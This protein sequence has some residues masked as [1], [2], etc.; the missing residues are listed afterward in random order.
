MFGESR[1]VVFLS[2]KSGGKQTAPHSQPKTLERARGRLPGCSEIE[3][4]ISSKSGNGPP[5]EGIEQ[6]KEASDIFERLGNTVDQAECLICL[7]WALLDDKQLDAAEEAVSRAIDLLS[8]KGQQFRVC[9]GHRLLG[10]IYRSKG[11]TK[12]AIHHFEVALG[13]ASS[14][15]N[16]TELFWIHYALA[17]V[18]FGED[19]FD[20]AHAHIERAKSHAINNAYPGSC[21]GA[22]SCVLVPATHV[23]KGKARGFACRRRL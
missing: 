20:D 15:N 6:A 18:F 12:E 22:T 8:E 16:H 5:E 10:L 13:I 23:W 1:T 19:R 9:E 3:G 21:D 17:Q 7:A 14:L 2:R 11:D 4:P